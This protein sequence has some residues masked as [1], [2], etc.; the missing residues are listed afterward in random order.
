MLSARVL[1]G[2]LLK[3]TSGATQKQDWR[4]LIGYQYIGR[5][6]LIS[7]IQTAKKRKN[8]AGNISQ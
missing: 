1:E 4:I 5:K 6:Y 2:F 3:S 7:Y 8:F